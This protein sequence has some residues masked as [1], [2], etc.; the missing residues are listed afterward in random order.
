VD[1]TGAEDDDGLG[2]ELSD[3][4]FSDDEG[5]DYAA[6]GYFDDG[7]GEDGYADDGDAGGGEGTFD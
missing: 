3:A 5:G 1:P 7:M 2:S 6:E 4:V